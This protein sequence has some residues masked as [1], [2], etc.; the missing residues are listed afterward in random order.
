MIIRDE[1]LLITGGNVVAAALI[2]IFEHWHYHKKAQNEQN[3]EANEIAQGHHDKRRFTETLLQWHTAASLENQLKGLG[4]KDSI[5]AA[6][7]LLNE[8][9]IISEHKN[10]NPS[11]RYDKTIHFLFDENVV[12]K[13]MDRFSKSI[14]TENRQDP[15][16]KTEISSTEN[17]QY[18]YISSIDDFSI[19]SNSAAEAA[20]DEQPPKIKLPGK[21]KKRTQGA[22]PD[23]KWQRWVDT[24]HDHVKR[25][26]GGIDPMLNPAQL[27]ALRK[28]R[29]YLC[30][31]AHKTGGDLD[32]DGF[33]VWQFIHTHWGRLEKWQQGELDLCVVLKKINNILNQ[34]KNGS[35]TLGGINADHATGTSGQKNAAFANY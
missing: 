15:E 9:G 12:F 4:K 1:H 14:E 34:L 31:I 30:K 32:D 20:G 26:N 8:L 35:K 13:L 28:L 5:L 19:D 27:G 23:K 7:K 16:R 21:Q 3:K 10:P 6:R 24:W 2:H 29:I 33:S 22:E 17:R 11:Y 25:L 18:Q